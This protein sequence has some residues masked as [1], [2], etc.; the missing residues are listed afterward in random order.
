MT[1]L[2]K[3]LLESELSR[4]GFFGKHVHARAVAIEFHAAIGER[5]EGPIAAGADVFAGMKFG[6]ALTNDDAA[7]GDE[8][9]AVRF[10][11]ETFGVTVT[12]V[13]DASLSFFMCHIESILSANYNLMSLIFTTVNS[14]R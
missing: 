7:G 8:F 13:A 14:W 3:F 4:G 2:A 10:Y 1:S 6:A 12:T 11:T 9:A 5:E